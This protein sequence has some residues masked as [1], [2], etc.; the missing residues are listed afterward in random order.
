MINV[1]LGIFGRLSP[2]LE[3]RSYRVEAGEAF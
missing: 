2:S 1:S 3:R